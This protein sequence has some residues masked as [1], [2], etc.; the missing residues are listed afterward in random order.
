MELGNFGFYRPGRRKADT[1]G[2][3]V[4]GHVPE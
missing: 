1:G 4:S 3:S 2:N